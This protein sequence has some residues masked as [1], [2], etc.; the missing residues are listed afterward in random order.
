M[1]KGMWGEDCGKNEG[2][3]LWIKICGERDMGQAGE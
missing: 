2:R 3:G 1:G